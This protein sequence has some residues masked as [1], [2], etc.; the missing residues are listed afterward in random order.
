MARTVGAG[1]R[2]GDPITGRPA[3]RPPALFDRPFAAVLFDMDGTLIDSLPSVR[4][5]WLRWAQE[6]GVD[7]VDLLAFHGVPA[8][9]IVETVLPPDRHDTGVERIETLEVEDA[10][11]IVVLP[12]AAEALRAVGERAAV[13]TSCTRA[14]A[15]ARI[16]ATG[17]PVPVHVVTA[18]DVRRGK[19][20]PE[21]YRLGAALLG[22]DPQDCLVVEDAPSGVTAARAAGAR[23]LGVLTGE[24]EPAGAD[25]LVE[26]V[27]AVRFRTGPDGVWVVRA[28]EP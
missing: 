1:A 14:L 4:R 5:S 11:G 27:S 21:P 19:P 6:H 22:V 17:L 7:P 24:V 3:A 8:R 25:V 20:D 16:A 12:G 13:V 10:E 28:R 18:G 26:S 15:D 23:T 9:Q 2:E